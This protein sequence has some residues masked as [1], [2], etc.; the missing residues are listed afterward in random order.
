MPTPK[1]QW[2]VQQE[3]GVNTNYTIVV[4]AFIEGN[5]KIETKTFTSNISAHFN[6]K[7]QTNYASNNVELKITVSPAT[8]IVKNISFIPTNELTKEVGKIFLKRYLQTI[9]AIIM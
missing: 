3:K 2:Q 5:H 4:E 7:F 1:F 8:T 9:K 6:Y